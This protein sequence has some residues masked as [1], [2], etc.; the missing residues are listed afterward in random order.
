MND[1]T[2]KNPLRTIALALGAAVL[3]LFLWK[4]RGVVL[5]IFLAVIFG[6]ALSRATDWFEKRRIPRTVAAPLLMLLIVGALAATVAAVAP[7]LHKQTRQLA[8]ELPKI[9]KAVARVLSS[10]PP[11]QQQ[12]PQGKP[13][14]KQQPQPAPQPAP[15][16]QQPAAEEGG[17]GLQRIM[18]RELQGVGRIL[19]PVISTTFEAVAGIL[20]IIFVAIYI[21]VS[22]KTYRD[23]LLHLVP[24]AQRDRA[25][26]VL[27]E[28]GSTLR[29]W[30]V[31]RLI[32]VVVIGAVTTIGLVLL[33]VKAALAL[34]VIA[35]IL[36]FIPFFGPVLAAVPALGSALIDS[37]QKAIYVGI[38]YVVIQQFEGNLLT[39]LL[40]K[41]R[42]EIP[43]VLTIVAVSAFG[44]VFG[45][46]G[47]ITA[48]PLLAALL[49]FV[50]LLYV[51]DVVGDDVT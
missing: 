22:P 19:F 11:Q 26:D 42:L 28:A 32:A 40:L 18:G 27:A 20:V 50:K 30:L 44:V 31:A 6:L 37:P 10:T 49:V 24:H 9:E 1:G 47:M 36:E 7:S 17:G 21:A 48:E 38:L 25:R 14:A 35:G 8:T 4:T 29:Q 45:V 3:L 12:Q 43:P 16:Q 2:R 5:T 15:P 23:G 41:S 39:P 51:E 13:K 34:G 46:L 33:D